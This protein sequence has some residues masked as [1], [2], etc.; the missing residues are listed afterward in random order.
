MGAPVHLFIHVRSTTLHRTTLNWLREKFTC[1]PHWTTFWSF[2]LQTI[3]QELNFP[4][5]E[6]EK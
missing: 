3:S 6:T 4:S 2:S 1:L 5:S